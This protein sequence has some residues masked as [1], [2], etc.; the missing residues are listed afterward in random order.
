MVAEVRANTRNSL[1]RAFAQSAVDVV[2]K[3]MY[4]L[5]S[6]GHVAPVESAVLKPPA[7]RGP[8]TVPLVIT[9]VAIVAVA[10]LALAARRS[11]S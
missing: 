5:E 2:M 9:V 1:I 3:H 8:V 11:W 4:L 10:N 7:P 6:T